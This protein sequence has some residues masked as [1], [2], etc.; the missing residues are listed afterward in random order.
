MMAMMATTAAARATMATMAMEVV[1]VVATVTVGDG[2]VD[3][4][5][6]ANDGAGGSNT[7]IK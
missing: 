3:N 4:D 2:C 6:E 5:N 1:V 7:T